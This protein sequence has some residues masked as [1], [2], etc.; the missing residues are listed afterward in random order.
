MVKQ[1]F[2]HYNCDYCGVEEVNKKEG[3]LKK[4]I[5]ISRGTTSYFCDN[6]PLLITYMKNGWN[7]YETALCKKQKIKRNL[8]FCCKECLLK[9][10]LKHLGVPDE[11]SKQI[12]TLEPTKP[13]SRFDDIDSLHEKEDK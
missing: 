11:I 5:T 4:W 6:E 8:Y 3:D 1:S 13:V 2:E 9:F 7:E 10:M 12:I